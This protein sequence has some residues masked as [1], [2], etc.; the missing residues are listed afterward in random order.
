MMKQFFGL[1]IVVSL[2]AGALIAFYVNKMAALSF[3]IGAAFAFIN[4]LFLTI[5]MARIFTK[6]PVAISFSLIIFKY[7]IF[8]LALYFL[9]TSN[10]LQLAW[11]MV[12][13]SILVISVVGLAILYLLDLKKE[14]DNQNNGTL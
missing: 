8:G 10:F 11:F 6:K 4:T 5:V 14:R 7:L 2:L 9:V 12:G 1:Q 3:G 13:L